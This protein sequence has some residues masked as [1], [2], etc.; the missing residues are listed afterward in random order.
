MMKAIS[1]II[2][3]YEQ[4]VSLCDVKSQDVGRLVMAELKRIG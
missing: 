3:R 1:R 2:Y 4:Q